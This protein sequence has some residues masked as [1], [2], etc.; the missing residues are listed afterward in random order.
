VQQRNDKIHLVERIV[1][2]QIGTEPSANVY[3]QVEPREFA[4]RLAK[5]DILIW[6]RLEHALR[7]AQE[8]TGSKFVNGE[9]SFAP[10]G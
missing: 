10:N 2:S 8:L 1:T 4:A 9:Y 7:R 6:I 3:P 5:P